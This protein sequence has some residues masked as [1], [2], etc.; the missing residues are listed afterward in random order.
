MRLKPIHTK[1]IIVVVILASAVGFT[2]MLSGGREMPEVKKSGKTVP[3]VST[4]PVHYTD[5]PTE[6]VAYGRVRSATPLDITSENQ[7]KILKGQVPLKEG[8]KFRKGQ[9]LFKVDDREAQLQLQANKSSFLKDIASILPTF[10]ID[11]PKSY[12]TWQAYFQKIDVT[13]PLPTLPKHAT[14]KE[15]TFLATQNIYSNYYQIKSTETRLAKYNVY[16]PFTGSFV[17]VFLQAGSFTNPGTKVARVLESSNLELEV[18]VDPKDLQWIKVGSKVNIQNEAGTS[19]WAGRVTRVAEVM[20]ANTQAIDIFVSIDRGDDKVYDGMYLKT[21]IPGA[22]IQNGMEIPRRALVE[23]SYVY[24][25]SDTL[26]KL[27]E[28]NVLKINA[29]TAIISGVNEGT[30]LVNEQL[31]NAY[32]DMVAYRL[33]DYNRNTDTAKSQESDDQVSQNN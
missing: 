28:V 15:K 30:N 1:I 33:S 12:L 10:K 14:A 7:G 16:A 17:E 6:V 3:Y 11:F 20:D 19:Q 22:T 24:V 18:P 8:Q 21:V 25:L 2:M 26:L 13:K 31:L 27:Q 9:L 5:I 4:K 23:N 29:E 32:E